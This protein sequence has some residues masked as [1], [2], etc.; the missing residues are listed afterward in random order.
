[1]SGRVS[2][3]SPAGTFEQFVA[4]IN[5]HDLETLTSLMTED[6]LFVDSLGNHVRGANIM[7]TGW[8]SYF[9]MCPD[10]WIRIRTSLSGGDTVLSTGE[11]GGT[12]DGVSWHTPAAWEALIRGRFV[13]EWRVF[14]DNKQVFEILARRTP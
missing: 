7:Q 1:M 3:E 12:I 10:Y 9:T 14:A 5:G 11:A 2:A 13:S 8:R 6:H 4:A